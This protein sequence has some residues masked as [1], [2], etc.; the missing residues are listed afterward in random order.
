MTYIF[1]V[2]HNNFML[3]TW[4]WK[5]VGDELEPFECVPAT[6]GLELWLQM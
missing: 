2:I 5:C 3:I 1:F 6:V 4:A